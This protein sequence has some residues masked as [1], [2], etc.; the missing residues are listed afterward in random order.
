MEHCEVC[1]FVWELVPAAELP[2]RVAEVGPSFRR[3][4]L[5]PDRPAGWAER[6]ATRPSPDVWSAI[7]YACHVRDVVLTNRER[8]LTT[9]VLDEPHFT[10]MFRDERVR[11]AGYASEDLTEVVGQIEMATAMFARAMARLDR[12]QLD[13][14]CHYGFPDPAVRTVAWVGA[15]TVHEAEHHLIDIAAQLAPFDLG[16]EHV[17]RSPADVGTVDLIVIRPDI[18]QRLVVAEALLTV[19][20]G[21]DGDN[22]S[23][24]S[25]RRTPDGSALVDAQ[26]TLMSS[27]AA[28]LFAG[29]RDRWALAGDQLYVDLDISE[30]ALP[31][32]TRLALGTADHRGDARTPPRT[33]PS[34]PSATGSTCCGQSTRRRVGPCACA[35]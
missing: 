28:Q 10:P 12:P 11:L 32:G 17:R 19:A 2:S 16:L 23:S 24:R 3:L 34:S 26:L 31:A 18:D 15:Q 22:W 14:R 4:M 7:E 30:A 13:R 35:A 25:S 9:L 33:A 21:I 8:V 5:P 20:N 1:G 6:A 27:R 29:D